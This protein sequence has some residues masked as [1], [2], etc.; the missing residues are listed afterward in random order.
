MMVFVCIF[1]GI[2]DET[3]N[4]SVLKTYNDSKTYNVCIE[5]SANSKAS[6]NDRFGW[7]ACC[8]SC[9]YATSAAVFTITTGYFI[10]SNNLFRKKL[11]HSTFTCTTSY[12]VS[13]PPHHSTSC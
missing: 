11:E 10:Y 3:L 12:K 7:I 5:H 1:K 2:I 9:H 13:L 4:I 8:W 6:I